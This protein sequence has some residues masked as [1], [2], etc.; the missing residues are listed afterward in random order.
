MDKNWGRYTE[1]DV[2]RLGLMGIDGNDGIVAGGQ[3]GNDGSA[4]TAE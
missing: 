4:E 2:N 3:H 1:I